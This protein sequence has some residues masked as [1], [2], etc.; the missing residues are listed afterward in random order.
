M[1]FGIGEAIG[2]VTGLV[3]AFG[4]KKKQDDGGYG[5][6]PIQTPD[7]AEMSAFVKPVLK[8]WMTKPPQLST[9]K[10][11]NSA[12]NVGGSTFGFTPGRYVQPTAPVASPSSP[13][14]AVQ[15]TA[16]ANMPQATTTTTAPDWVKNRMTELS[17]ILQKAR[18]GGVYNEA[19]RFQAELD[20][21]KAQYGDVTAQ[22]VSPVQNQ[23]TVTTQAGPTS[24][25]WQPGSLQ[26]ADIPVAADTFGSLGN[27][28]ANNKYLDPI[29]QIGRELSGP[30]FGTYNS[31]DRTPMINRVG[32]DISTPEVSGY[33]NALEGTVQ[34]RLTQN[35]DRSLQEGYGT[36]YL[37]TLANQ[38]I[39]PLREAFQDA[40]NAATADYNARGLAGSGFEYGKKYGT[41][42]D[43]ISR[44]YMD[45][46]SDLE[47]DIATRGAEAAREDRFRNAGL[48]DTATNT[49]LGL[50]QS[51]SANQLNRNQADL[52]RELQQ[53]NLMESELGLLSNQDQTNEANRQFWTQQMQDTELQNRELQKLGVDLGTQSD[54]MNESNRQWWTNLLSGQ[55]EYD[56]TQDQQ[57]WLQNLNLNQWLMER[58]DATAEKNRLQALDLQAQNIDLAQ[59]P[60]QAIMN[61][62]NGQ[63]VA[64]NNMQQNYWNGQNTQA[65]NEAQNQNDI[66]TLAQGLGG[67]FTKQKQ[68]P[69]T[70]TGGVGNS[71]SGLGSTLKTLF[72]L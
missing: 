24:E 30:G 22:A 49:A 11:Q 63:N 64:A 10:A 55:Q 44:R 1:V 61:F 71:L 23:N 40:I 56:N 47:A 34:N 68:A 53:R 20:G 21:L 54:Q 18:A 43:S 17:N 59:E 29:A 9:P 14:G 19:K 36:E 15:P 67:L 66:A 39:A 60:I 37:T 72:G 45:A 32:A 26:I 35:M 69:V 2:A 6:A 57:N 51:Q 65:A 31:V 7:Q 5:A 27:Y 33:N 4:G 3:S 42:T 41:G 12:V 16:Q 38:G 13:M 52:G 58:D 28:Q 48:Q 50:S 62:I 25:I 8:D 70:Y 46:V